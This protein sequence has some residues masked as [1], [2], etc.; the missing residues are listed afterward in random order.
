[1]YLH[2]LFHANRCQCFSRR[3][4]CPLFI[5]CAH[6]HVCVCIFVC[7]RAHTHTRARVCAQVRRGKKVHR[8]TTRTMKNLYRV[9]GRDW[10]DH[11]IDSYQEETCNSTSSPFPTT[12]SSP[13]THTHFS[14]FSNLKDKKKKITRTELA[15]PTNP[16]LNCESGPG[17]RWRRGRPI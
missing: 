9:H 15:W 3:C 2:E 16:Q 14:Y 5:L 12:P 10:I 6:P 7:V 1:M 13:K 11:E 8:F 17:R 4:D